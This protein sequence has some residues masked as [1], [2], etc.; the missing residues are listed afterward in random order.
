MSPE[1]DGHE[2]IQQLMSLVEPSSKYDALGIAGFNAVSVAGGHATDP[3]GDQARQLATRHGLPGSAYPA[4]SAV[5]ESGRGFPYNAAK[6]GAVTAATITQFMQDVAAGKAVAGLRSEPTDSASKHGPMSGLVDK[7][8]GLAVE[9]FVRQALSAT[10]LDV[11]L[12]VH[13][14]SRGERS[15]Y[16]AKLRKVAAKLKHVESLHLGSLNLHLNDLP[17]ALLAEELLGAEPKSWE[18]VWIF[19][20]GGAKGSLSCKRAKRKAGLKDLAKWIKRSVSVAFSAKPPKLPAGDYGD[21][22]TDCRLIKAGSV[23]FC[24][25]CPTKL[26]NGGEAQAR[27]DACKS[28]TNAN[29]TLACGP[30][31][32]T[33]EG[34]MCYGQ[35]PAGGYIHTCGGCAQ[36]DGKL[37][38]THCEDAL[39]DWG[40]SSIEVKAC[41]G[42]IIDNIGGTL[43]CERDD[44]SAAD[45]K[46]ADEAAAVDVDSAVVKDKEEL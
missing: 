35:I 4:L 42:K 16:D 1:G 5:D 7:S 8:V 32:P 13:N 30:R 10:D 15:A 37:E 22:C 28:F 29:G 41:S 25:A 6:R 12:A 19:P 38:C 9:A 40:A 31:P 2:A 46:K 27:V 45:A 39:G 11:V 18:G 24:K 43:V 14:S 3:S 33:C 34:E 17:A 21:S 20:A 26:T 36:S 44:T 23:L